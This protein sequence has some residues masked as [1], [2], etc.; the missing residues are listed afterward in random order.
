MGY[1]HLM[2]VLN[3]SLSGSIVILMVMLCRIPL[4][5]A[6]M[7]FS[8]ALWGT[9]L[10][11]LL[12]PVS[13]PAR[14][15]LLSPFAHAPGGITAVLISQDFRQSPLST[16]NTATVL[17][18][19][20]NGQ[21]QAYFQPAVILWLCGCA[22]VLLYGGVSLLL[23]RRRL[24]GRVKLQGNIYLADHIPSPFVLGIVRPKIYLPSGLSEAEQEIIILHEQTHIR[25]LDHLTRLL[26]F[27][28][29]VLHWFNPLVWAAYFLSERDMET[30]CDE[31]VLRKL[32]TRSSANYADTLLRLSAGRRRFP[33][34][35]AFGEGNIK[36]RIKNVPRYK[37]PARWAAAAAALL[38]VLVG[39]VCITNPV[40]GGTK[41]T[42]LIF[43]LYE[44]EKTPITPRFLRGRSGCPF[45]V[46]QS[47]NCAEPGR[48]PC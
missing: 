24:V 34:P 18:A 19:Q 37:R 8:Y 29:L 30:S 46:R 38:A 5:K 4:R 27:I 26:G 47:G 9:A 23:L 3:M 22:A 36:L 17:L 6:P 7:V 48:I 45:R 21:P 40:A 42:S 2:I 41:T 16:D 13:L 39:A 32:T 25:R 15:S 44:D 12:C 31:A 1:Y 10:F 28:A 43:P 35:P 33:A 20:G 14:F 11:R